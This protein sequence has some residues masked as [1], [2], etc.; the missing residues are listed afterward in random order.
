MNDV[1]AMTLRNSNK[2]NDFKPDKF[3]SLREKMEKRTL[4]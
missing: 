2:E 4:L 3:K 1:L